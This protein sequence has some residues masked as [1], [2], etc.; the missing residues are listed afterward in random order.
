M[1]EVEQF[2]P[3]QGVRVVSLAQ[4]IAG[5]FASALLGDLGADVIGIENPRGRDTSRPTNKFLQG[6]GTQMDRRNSRSLCMDVRKGKGREIFFQMLKDTDILIEGFR[7]GQMLKWDMSDETLWEI[8]PKLVIVHISGFGQY[9]AEGYVERASFD[10]I[11]QAFG[12][13][14][15]M[16]GFADR[17]PVPA[18]PQPSDYF[19]GLFGDVAALAAYH[20]AQVTGKGESIDVAQFEAMQR[21]SGFYIMNYLN[22]GTLPVREGS[23]STTSA[24]YG[25]YTCSDGVALYILALGAGVV[26]NLLPLLDIKQGEDPLFPVGMPVVALESEAGKALEEKLAEFFGNHT[27]AEAEKLLLAAGV[28]CSRINSFADC[29]AD[30]H[31]QAREVFTSWKNEYDD[32]E[33]RGVNV[34]PRLKNNPGKITRGMPLVGQ[35]NEEILSSCGVSEEEIA[36]LYE[37]GII[38]KEDT[39]FG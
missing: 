25:A 30:P 19:T 32:E 20:R 36:A 7:G 31:Y 12:G 11:G 6:W 21:V 1:A 17:L 22:T 8:N 39:I 4:A 9:G 3:L 15:Y 10:G 14:M 13:Y 2:G 18:F 27:A 26:R 37:E 16:N 23:H 35:H 29:V 24:G 34:I 28:P 5:P 38:R 33:I